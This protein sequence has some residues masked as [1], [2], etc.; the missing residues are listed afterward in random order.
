M[1]SGGGV[2]R[3]EPNQPRKWLSRRSFGARVGV[4]DASSGADDWQTGSSSSSGGG[5]GSTGRFSHCRHS[6]LRNRSS[7]G[8]GGGG[9]STRG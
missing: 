1:V 6:Y 3:F 8:G 9:G 7:G 2:R 4:H 5:G